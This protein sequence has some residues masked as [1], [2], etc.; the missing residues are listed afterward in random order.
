[1]DNDNEKEIV[2][3]IARYAASLWPRQS[4]ELTAVTYAAYAR[5]LSDISAQ[6]VDMSL[7]ELARTMTFFPAA[8]EIRTVAEKIIVAAAGQKQASESEAWA[9]VQQQVK[10]SWTNKTPA[11]SSAEIALA[12]KRFGWM[13][14]CTLQTNEVGIARAQFCR[15]Y[16]EII[17]TKKEKSK[18][19]QLLSSATQAQKNQ[20]AAI[21]QLTAKAAET[22]T[23]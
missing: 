7:A 1:M 8:A 9:E 15:F 21:A 19:D 4:K 5:V 6:V 18:I 17:E 16:K 22:H 10:T 13:E 20:L 12:A 23:A 3:I 2:R 11:F 14:L